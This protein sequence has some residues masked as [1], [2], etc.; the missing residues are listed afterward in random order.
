MP[1]RLDNL[2]NMAHDDLLVRLQHAYDD[3]F[4]PLHN[5]RAAVVHDRYVRHDRVHLHAEHADGS[6]SGD[7]ER[8]RGAHF[9]RS[10]R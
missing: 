3:H 8:R 2:R 7:D 5:D 4:Y 6:R 9:R 10:G 1:A